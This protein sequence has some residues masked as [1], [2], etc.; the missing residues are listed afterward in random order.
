M[1]EHEQRMNPAPLFARL[2][3]EGRKLTWFAG[4]VGYS[5]NTVRQIKSGRRSATRGFLD[6]AARLLGCEPEVLFFLDDVR[7]EIRDTMCE[8]G[9]Q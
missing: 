2:E 1:I 4:E 7:T 8:G 6:A 5:I 9:N 3:R